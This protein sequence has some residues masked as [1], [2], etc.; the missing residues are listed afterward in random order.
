MQ[1]LFD[2]TICG[3]DCIDLTYYAEEDSSIYDIADA[4]QLDFERGRLPREAMAIFRKPAFHGDVFRAMDE[5]SLEEYL[6]GR[7][8]EGFLNA[9]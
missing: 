6:L 9:S 2:E 3:L 1:K 7:L 5:T 8:G 4:I